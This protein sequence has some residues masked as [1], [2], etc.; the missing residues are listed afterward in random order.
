ME[1]EHVMKRAVLSAI[2]AA[3]LLLAGA[4]HAELLN[5]YL[6]GDTE[7][8]AFYDTD[9]NITWLRDA[10]MNGL[11]DWN[12]ADTWANTLVVGGIG[13][14]RLPTAYGCICNTCGDMGHLWYAELGNGVPYGSPMTNT[15]DFQNLHAYNYWTGTEALSPSSRFRFNMHYG[16]L[17]QGDTSYE[18][19]AMAVH[20]GDVGAVPEPEACALMLTGLAGL[21]LARRQRRR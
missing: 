2:G 4:A 18:A 6:D 16:L 11:M 14:W 13:G 19:Y 8:D 1:T 10:D 7:V 3:A 20:P 12:A 17:G 15:G 9:L 5:R 21:A